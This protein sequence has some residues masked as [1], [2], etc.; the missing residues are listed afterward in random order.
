M[1][2][3]DV[4]AVPQAVHSVTA[5]VVHHPQVDLVQSGLQP[6]LLGG[7][8]PPGGHTPQAQVVV[9][10][11]LLP[12]VLGRQADGSEAGQGGGKSQQGQVVLVV[13]EVGVDE[14]GLHHHLHLPALAHLPVPVPQ[15]HAPDPAAQARDEL[16]RRKTLNKE[17]QS[18]GRSI[19]SNY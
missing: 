17:L 12:L 15:H 5:P 11:P 18:N 14:D 4:D 13:G 9:P 19:W 7:L 1:A 3:V 6:R 8:A 2:G 10:L 16:T